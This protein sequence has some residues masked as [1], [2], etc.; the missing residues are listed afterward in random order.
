MF[1]GPLLMTSA[2][3]LVTYF[4][5]APVS[6]LLAVLVRRMLAGPFKPNNLTLLPTEIAYLRHGPMHA[7][8]VAMVALIGQRRLIFQRATNQVKLDS[9]PVPLAETS[10]RVSARMVKFSPLEKAIV[11]RV[12]SGIAL[13]KLRHAAV[14]EAMAI[15]ETHLLTQGFLMDPSR[16][17]LALW[18][19]MAIACIVPALG[20][21]W[22]WTTAVA[23]ASVGFP[24][25]LWVVWALLLH[26]LFRRT[27]FERPR[28]TIRGET[29]LR[30]LLTKHEHLF[31]RQT[32]PE[33]PL[34]AALFGKDASWVSSLAEE[35]AGPVLFK[36]I[37]P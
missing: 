17:R 16:A 32:L 18:L 22:I 24:I 31:Y 10:Y 26:Q 6:A 14:Q 25:A 20:L 19:P 34:A 2:E 27:L 36:S 13:S 35:D 3:F 5:A 33:L 1:P 8:D 37:L 9:G 11:Q 23:S 29:Y 7:V 28:L 4:L 15:V 21:W 30:V 12:E